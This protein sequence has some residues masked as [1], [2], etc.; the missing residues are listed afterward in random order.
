MLKA[1]ETPCKKRGL[2]MVIPIS[3][4]VIG[5]LRGLASILKNLFCD[6]ILCHHACSVHWEGT[7][8]SQFIFP[9]Y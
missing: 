6:E 2:L 8:L 5:T 1:D 3:Q 4:K 9:I 7:L